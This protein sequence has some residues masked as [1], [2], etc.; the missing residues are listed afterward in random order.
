MNQIDYMRV[1]EFLNALETDVN[2]V[3]AVTDSTLDLYFE[4]VWDQDILHQFWRERDTIASLMYVIRDILSE[5][6]TET[7]AFHNKVE[8]IANPDKQEQAV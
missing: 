8:D 2:K 7:V 6:K 3:I 1:E 4:P 5:I